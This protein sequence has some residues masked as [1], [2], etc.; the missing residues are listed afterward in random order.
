MNIKII[1]NALKDYKRKKSVVETTLSRIEQYKEALS[2]PDSF[3]YVFLGSP[4]EPGMPRST[5]GRKS[6]VELAIEDK[7]K[8]IELL[9]E[10]IKDD[11]S[12]I[13]PYQ[14]ELEQI[15]GA[16]NALTM[17]ERYIIECKHIEK[18]FWRDIEISFN[19]KFRQ[20]N[21]LTVSGLKKVNRSA[22]EIMAKILEPYYTRF[23]IKK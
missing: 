20:Q 3:E 4:R 22:L 10:W 19:E 13:Y 1:E 7:E 17:Q 8:A 9:K 21:Y 14:I 16:L 18:M 5:G 15:N 2:N 12:R 11:H 6:S 23:K